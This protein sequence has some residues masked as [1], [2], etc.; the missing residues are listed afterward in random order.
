[1]SEFS[2]DDRER[3][4]AEVRHN[5]ESADA[6]ANIALEARLEARLVA[7]LASRSIS[8]LKNCAAIWLT[9]LKPS[10]NWPTASV[11]RSRICEI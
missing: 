5:L 8:G 1:M 2:P 4:L 7:K 6:A 9:L 10:A 3:I 11:E